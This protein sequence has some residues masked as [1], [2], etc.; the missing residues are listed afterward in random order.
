MSESSIL[1]HGTSEIMDEVFEIY[2][3]SLYRYVIYFYYFRQYVMILYT[4]DFLQKP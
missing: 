1:F 4:L 2:L 3:Y